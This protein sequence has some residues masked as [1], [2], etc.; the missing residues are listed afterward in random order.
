MTIEVYDEA[1][2]LV[3]VVAEQEQMQTGGNV[4]AWDGKDADGDIVH[5]G[6]YIVVIRVGEKIRAKMTVVVWNN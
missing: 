5:S 1:G 3:R 6:I 4:K 2:R